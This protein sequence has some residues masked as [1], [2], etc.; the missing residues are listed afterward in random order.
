MTDIRSAANDT[1][2]QSETLAALSEETLASMEEVSASM[3][4]IL[5]MM[6]DN[7]SAL[8]TANNSIEEIASGAQASAQA[9]TNGAEGA[10]QVTEKS[11]SSFKELNEALEN[12]RNAEEVSTQ[13]IRR[14]RELEHSV[15]SIAGFVSTITSIAD[16]TNL[17]ALNAAIEAA[18]Y[19]VARIQS[20]LPGFATFY[21][22]GLEGPAD[23]R[24]GRD[25]LQHHIFALQ[26]I[27][28]GLPCQFH[29]VFKPLNHPLLF[30][31]GQSSVLFQSFAQ[32][33]KSPTVILEP[34]MPAGS[35]IGHGCFHFCYGSCEYTELDNLADE[36]MKT[37]D[38]DQAAGRRRH[39]PPVPR[40]AL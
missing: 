13:S 14:L 36:K 26:I 3:E 22:P 24:A 2:R 31:L 28:Q 6:E 17:L 37:T 11:E 39:T 35:G 5:H 29:R 34:V 38:S 18:R 7:A 4:R 32:Q 33:K 27:L 20:L 25:L 30:Q 15:E 12:I 23:H 8:Q 40:E 1:A 10:A 19:A 9:A 16:Q 21:D